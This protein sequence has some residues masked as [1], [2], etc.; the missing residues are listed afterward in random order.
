MTGMTSCREIRH[1]LGVYVLG[2]IE[3]AERALVDEHLA[4]C[5]D[6]REELASLAGLPAMLRK[7]PLAE[8]ERLA[9]TTE[10]DADELPSEA[11]LNSLVARTANVRRI[12]RWRRVT[13]AAAVIVLALGGGAAAATALEHGPAA[14]QVHWHEAVGAGPAAG[15]RLIVMYRSVPGATVIRAHVA[16]LKPGTPCEFRLVDSSGQRWALGSWRAASGKAWVWYPASASV[17][18]PDVRT[19]QVLVNGNVAVSAAT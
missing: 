7:V 12:H 18:E 16:G 11:M 6:C 9:A 15:V 3:P 1:A 4:T 19:F 8:A 14:P 13:A 5:P 17:P 10:L 2:A